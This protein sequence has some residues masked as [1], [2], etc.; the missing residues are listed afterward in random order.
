MM[1]EDMAVDS[2]SPR[3]SP[4]K[5]LRR[6]SRRD[7]NTSRKDLNGSNKGHRRTL[8]LPNN[9]RVEDFPAPANSLFRKPGLSFNPYSPEPVAQ[10]TLNIRSHRLL[11]CNPG[12]RFRCDFSDIE[13]VGQ[14]SFS[15]V[16][17]CR[18]NIDTR[19]YAIKK[20]NKRG[21]ERM[22][23][24]SARSMSE[25]ALLEVYAL[26]SQTG[27]PNLVT[28]YDAWMEDADL[29]IQLEYCGESLLSRV[30]PS[31]MV[32]PQELLSIALQLNLALQWLHSRGVVHRDVKPENS[33][34]CPPRTYKLGDLGSAALEHDSSSSLHSEDGEGDARYLCREVLTSSVGCDWTKV[35]MFALGAMLLELA[36]GKRLPNS[37]E[38]WQHLRA[39]GVDVHLLSHLCPE[40][41]QT[42]NGLL[43]QD[44]AARPAAAEVSMHLRQVTGHQ[45][46][47]IVASR[48]PDL[49][50]RVRD[51]AEVERLQRDQLERYEGFVR[52]CADKIDP[53]MMTKLLESA[54]KTVGH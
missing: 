30:D 40:L 42:I 52:A 43:L 6:D 53:K 33:F 1:S 48:K 7:G 4:F 37:G 10:R 9:T 2:M 3:C 20:L 22:M 11:V 17:K 54:K 46:Q 47:Q 5:R 41:V 36:Q 44:P 19:L 28:Y 14:G 32:S 13:L 31:T 24:S 27:H 39:H 50:Q 12:S 25:A 38:D 35:D 49:V 26:S 21:Q 23:S 15:E 45:E 8:T 34:E 16:F 29:F 51:L 18:H